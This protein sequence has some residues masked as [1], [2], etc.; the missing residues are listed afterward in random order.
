[1]WSTVFKPKKPDFNVNLNF[2]GPT[3]EELAAQQQAEREAITKEHVQRIKPL[4]K[5]LSN[6]SYPAG[7]TERRAEADLKQAIREEK[8][9]A[10][11]ALEELNAKHRKV[12][13]GRARRV[14]DALTETMVGVFLGWLKTRDPEW[15]ERLI[16]LHP[17]LKDAARRGVGHDLH[18]NM[19]TLRFA[20]AMLLHNGPAKTSDYAHG[21]SGIA[22]TNLIRALEAADVEQVYDWFCRTELALRTINQGLARF[23]NANFV[24]RRLL[25]SDFMEF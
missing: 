21:L 6:L 18:G 3:V 20:E 8:E 24:W 25:M 10:K 11:V 12:S 13:E 7:D 22:S 4:Q 14:S 5:K 15:A 2:E 1:M 9:R 17:Q 19:Y 16:K 23:E